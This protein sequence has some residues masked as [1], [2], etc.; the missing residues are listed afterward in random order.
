[1]KL[2]DSK[3]DL[4]KDFKLKIDNETEGYGRLQCLSKFYKISKFIFLI[5][6]LSI[7]I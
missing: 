7:L 2:K 5:F 6:Y 4:Q 3:W 1:M